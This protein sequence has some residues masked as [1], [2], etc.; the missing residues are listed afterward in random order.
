MI[1]KTLKRLERAPVPAI[2]ILLFAAII[3]VIICALQASN[4]AELRNYEETWKS[5]P[6]TVTVT[7]PSGKNTDTFLI[8][9][10]VYDLFTKEE[11]QV[12]YDVSAAKSLEERVDLIADGDALALEV[13]LAEY[14]KDVQV[15][16]SRTINKINDKDYKSP[17]L[18]G[19]TSLFCD[20][21]LLPE[22]GCDITWYEGFD[23]SIF[24]G[25]Q[26][27]CLIPAGEVEDYDNGSG[28]VV[29]D[30]SNTGTPTV[31]IVDGKPVVE[32]DEHEYQCT[33]KIVGTYTAGDEKSIYCP[34]PIV[35]QIVISE[36]E[37]SL[38]IYSLS[39]T[40]A[41]N[42]RLEEFR[43]KMNL[44][45]IE[46]TPDAEETPWGYAVQLSKSDEPFRSTYYD[47]Y[48]YALD[49]NDDNLFDLSAILED[50]IKFNQTVTVFVVVLSVVAGFLVGFLMIRRR[51]RDIMLMRTVGESNF[52]LYVG[53]VIEQMICIIL[54][55]AVGGAY[56]K[57][58]P[59]NNLAI[60]AIVYFVGLT[61][62]LVIFLRS[63]L[64]T[65][66]KEDE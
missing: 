16:M 5:V 40:L 17:N 49:I 34:V 20:K 18:I 13:S 29:L 54:G 19:I 30:F 23:E 66:V 9:T 52:R 39:A 4:E 15:R 37:E 8:N 45:F 43:E 38:Y 63:K 32:I 1:K 6:I 60:F 53:F 65:T 42:N 12:F 59:I 57:W 58:N 56:Y 33:F 47:F 10:W 36:L 62:A 55:I 48:P 44:C 7:E 2:A 11:P 25:E 21:Q 51:K 41:D 64:L 35:E 22:Y 3:S 27:V 24:D 50:S 61:L 14:I 28:E 26:L 31:T 46:P